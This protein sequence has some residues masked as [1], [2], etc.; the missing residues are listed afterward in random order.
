MHNTVKQKC[1]LPSNHTVNR[2]VKE[3][4]LPLKY[5]KKEIADII[6]QLMICIRRVCTVNNKPHYEKKKQIKCI[7]RQTKA[8]IGS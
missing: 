3:N 7:M 4:K 6:E 5:Q 2:K 8:Q 1:Y